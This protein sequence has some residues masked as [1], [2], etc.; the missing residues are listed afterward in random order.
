MKLIKGVNMY[1]YTYKIAPPEGE[2]KNTN[3]INDF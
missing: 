3:K 1:F 2:A